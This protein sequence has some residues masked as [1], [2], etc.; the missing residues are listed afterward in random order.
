PIN[1]PQ[2]YAQAK[3]AIRN[4]EQYWFSSEEESRIIET[5]VSFNQLTVEGELFKIYFRAAQPD[6]VG[7]WLTGTEI[8]LEIKTKSKVNLAI[9]KKSINRF[10]LDLKNLGISKKHMS[11][12]NVYHVVRVN[13]DSEK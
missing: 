5:N 10:G 3:K 12:G 9:N 4:N 2:L 7:E 6:E 11:K 8:L 1:Y 13:S